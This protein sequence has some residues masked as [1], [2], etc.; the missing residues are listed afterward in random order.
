[1]A[2]QAA[3]RGDDVVVFA[4]NPQLAP[5]KTERRALD[6]SDPAS[7]DGLAAALGGRPID[8]PAC[9]AGVC[10]AE[11][12]SAAASRRRRGRNGSPST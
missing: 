5:P 3:A 4:R 7:Q 8:L 10:P 1:M 9:N 2:R 6:A 11:A 12:V